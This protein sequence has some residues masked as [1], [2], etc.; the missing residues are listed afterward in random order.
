MKVKFENDR[1]ELIPEDTFE[2]RFATTL[3]RRM[4]DS[5]RLMGWYGDVRVDEK[6]TSG[7]VITW[8]PEQNPRHVGIGSITK[9]EEEV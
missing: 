3:I 6:E 8:I 1:L 2:T 7:Y 4:D 5:N 9:K